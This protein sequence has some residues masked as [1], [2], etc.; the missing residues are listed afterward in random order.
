MI[1]LDSITMNVVTQFDKPAPV[2]F[3]DDMDKAKAWCLLSFVR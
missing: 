3:A 1:Y 2:R